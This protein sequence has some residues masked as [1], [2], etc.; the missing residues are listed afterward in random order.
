MTILQYFVYKLTTRS[1]MTTLSEAQMTSLFWTKWPNNTDPIQ[2]S[3]IVNLI[4]CNIAVI[5]TLLD[6]N[7]SYS[8]F[9]YSWHIDSYL[10]GLKCSNIEY[11]LVFNLINNNRFRKLVLMSE[12]EWLRC[13]LYMWY[14]LS[15]H[16]STPVTEWG[17]LGRHSNITCN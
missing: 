16:S 5:A 17:L 6:I 9:M 1:I 12:Q 13:Q 8:L 2:I 10:Y 14:C 4:A 11:Y 7:I 15:S 3:P